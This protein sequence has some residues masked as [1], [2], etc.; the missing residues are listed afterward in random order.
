MYEKNA[1]YLETTYGIGGRS[2]QSSIDENR[3]ENYTN[4][5]FIAL[6]TASV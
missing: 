2:I 3:L 1:A 6:E 5:S 4:L